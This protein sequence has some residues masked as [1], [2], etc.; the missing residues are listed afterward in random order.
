MYLSYI[1]LITVILILS[2]GLV[3]FFRKSV[4]LTKKI[5]EIESVKPNLNFVTDLQVE[6]QRKEQDLMYHALVMTELRQANRA[7]GEYLAPFKYRFTK[8]K[9]QEDF[10]QA[11]A[12]VVRDTKR[13]PME[14]F[15]LMFKQMH[16]GFYEKLLCTCPDMTRSELQVCA[17]LRMNLTSKDMARLTNVTASTIDITRHRIRKKLGLEPSD[18]LTGHLIRF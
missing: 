2:G 5:R 6:L 10:Q 16:G 15:E 13:D 4:S 3:Y 8:K 18:S 7:I 11:L 1:I 12:E 9:D 14:D 17:L